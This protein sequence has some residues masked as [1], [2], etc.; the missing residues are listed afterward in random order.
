MPTAQD[1]LKVAAA[2]LGVGEAPPGSHH[3]E[4]TVWYGADGPWCAM[5]VSWSLAHGGFSNDGGT[6]LDV[7]GVV[8]TTRHGWAYVPYMLNNFR[9]A[10][11]A[12]QEPAVGDVVAYDWDGDGVL[13]HTGL[14]ETLLPDGTFFAIEG[15]HNQFVQRVHRSRS[16]V[17]AFCRPPYEGVAPVASVPG[18]VGGVPQFPGSCSP[19]SRDD[20]TRQVQQRLVDLGF[21]LDVDGIFGSATSAIVRSFQ[22]QKGL[23]VDGIV[24]PDTWNAMWT[25]ISAGAP[26]LDF[27]QFK[28]PGWGNDF[29]KLV[30]LINS[31]ANAPQAE[32]PPCALGAIVMR[33]S[34]GRNVL[35]KG[36]PP[37]PGAGVGYCQITYGVNWPDTE[38]P[39]FTFH[40]QIFDLWDPTSNL[41]VG[42]AAFLKLALAAM[43]RLRS[44][45]GATAMPLPIL[46]YA[47][48]SYN[49]GATKITDIISSGGDAA[50]VDAATTGNYASGTLAL[51]TRA[52]QASRMSLRS[53]DGA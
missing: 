51:Y 50:A 31:Q 14:V 33:E 52:V 29:P 49:A 45:V 43:Q 44:K 35:Q 32:V 53:V 8:Q 40:R 30:P 23:A 20:A 9:D 42:A 12:F 47:F 5:F 15:N 1:V 10:G 22:Q 13:D 26:E 36:K 38:H 34:G 37:G 39:T 3:N 28:D 19:G 48:A 2:K 17:E 41:Y 24:G 7:P 27:V 4:F 6:T 46:F 18:V 25:A 21:H 11:R 16:V